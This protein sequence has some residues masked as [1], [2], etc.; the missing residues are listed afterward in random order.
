M[1]HRVPV[2]RLRGKAPVA[3]ANDAE[4]NSARHSDVIC[5]VRATPD[6]A[7]ERVRGG[8]RKRSPPPRG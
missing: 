4:V 3:L 1:T 2:G 8:S 5:G 7:E 6:R